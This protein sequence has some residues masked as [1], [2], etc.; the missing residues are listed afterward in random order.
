MFIALIAGSRADSDMEQ[1]GVTRV[2]K[3]EYY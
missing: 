1:R 2:I 3:K